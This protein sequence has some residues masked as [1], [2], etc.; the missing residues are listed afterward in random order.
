MSDDP[1]RLLDSALNTEP[2]LRALLR[3]G[4]SELP[5]RDQLERVHRHLGLALAATVAAASSSAASTASGASAAGAVVS[6]GVLGT[7]VAAKVGTVVILVAAAGTAA[8]VAMRLG[9]EARPGAEVPRGIEVVATQTPAQ[10]IVVRRPEPAKAPGS[11][12]LPVSGPAAGTAATPTTRPIETPRPAAATSTTPSV[13]TVPQAEDELVL[14][15]RAS[16]A[17]ASRPEEALRLA[18]QDAFIYPAG[19][20]A[21]ERELIAIQALVRLGRRSEASLRADQFFRNFP[22]SAH[23]PRIL[24]LLGE[25]P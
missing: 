6:K 24:A 15:Q 4:R 3:V 2:E 23:R 22:G 1:K 12:S 17:V 16:D 9:V 5:D 20:L 19:V 25:Q 11:A 10:G 14:L 13:A 7:A 21:Q 8:A 18:D